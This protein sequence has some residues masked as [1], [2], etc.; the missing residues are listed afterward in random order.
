MSGAPHGT[1]SESDVI[2]RWNTR[3]A[4]KVDAAPKVNEQLEKDINVLRKQAATDGIVL[5]H[6]S[7]MA[8]AILHLLNR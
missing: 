1:E 5:F 6:Q 3:H 8:R 7:A 4:P 2:T